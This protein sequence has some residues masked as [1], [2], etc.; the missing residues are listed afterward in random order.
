M[1]GESMRRGL[2][3]LLLVVL[4]NAAGAVQGAERSAPPAV[5][6]FAAASLTDVF[7]EIGSAFEQAHRGV[8]VTFNFAASS[9][10]A[11]QIVEKAPAQV[12]ASADEANMKKVV[13]A[14][15]V[16]GAPRIFATNRLV[17]V[18]PKGNPKHVA[19]LADL[20]R[21]G[22]TVALAAPQVPAGKY[23][24]EA[25]AKAGVAVPQASQEV[26]VRAVLT[27]VA[28]DEADAGIVYV[29]DVRAAADR[30]DAVPIPEAQNVIA[31]Y[32]IAALPSAGDTARAF[33]DA[34]LSPAGQATLARFGFLAPR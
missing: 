15:A 8:A 34:V 5:T 25:F 17:I 1:V 2:L 4:A 26:D 33:V 23:A 3:R 7:R 13:D 24:A 21:P 9:T 27:R 30:V 18:V 32:P 22:L 10:L 29:T 19:S 20:S 31:R 11:A 14:G 12:F 28:M 6:V 16:Q